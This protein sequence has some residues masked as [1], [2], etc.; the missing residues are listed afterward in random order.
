MKTMLTI[1]IPKEIKNHEYRVSM[2]PVGVQ[3]AVEA[4]HRVLVQKG[5]GL[6]SGYSNEAY[7]AAGATLVDTAAEVFAGAGMVIKVKEPQSQEIAMLRKGQVLF[8]YLHLAA[9]RAQTDGLL[10]SGATA[11]A[12]ETLLDRNNRLPLLTPM[13][14]IAGRMAVQEG[15][16]YLEIPQKGRGILLGGVPGV[17]PA[18]VLVLGG[19]VV[20]TQAAKIAAG[21]GADVTIMDISLDRLRYLDDVMPANVKTVYSDP[22]AIADHARRADLVIGA[23]LIPG[24]KAPSLIK[25]SFLK[26]MLPGAVIVDV[27]VDQGGCFETTHATTH[28]NPTYIVDGVVHYCVANMPGAVGRT[29]TQALCHATQPY[30]LKL[31]DAVAAGKLE[32]LVNKDRSFNTALNVYQGAVTHPEVAHCFGLPLDARFAV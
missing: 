23:V 17:E 9:D 21:T 25:K 14:E 18:R 10:A 26:E 32:E 29:S 8:T 27:A 12:Y 28:E 19:G 22:Y 20:G 2:L 24:A 3:L 16:K 7:A 30:A 4:G 31:A 5:A 13:S 1:G 15:A 6:G 11:L